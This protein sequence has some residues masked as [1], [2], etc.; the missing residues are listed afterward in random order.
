LA[1]RERAIGVV[2][3]GD[4][5]DGTAGLAAIKQCG[6]TAIVQDPATAV[7]PSMPASALQNV[8]VDHCLPLERIPAALLRIVGR[9]A[10]P[11]RT[12]PPE[13]LQR[14]QALFDGEDVME[15]LSAV[16]KP[17]SLTCPHCGGGLWEVNG[18]RPLRYRCHTGHAFSARSLEN[19]S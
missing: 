14:E 18:P 1:W 17:S 9:G 8:A 7:Q 6:G 15:N 10:A 4:L 2:L 5:D 11:A 12:P 19:V 3:T 13:Q 16:G